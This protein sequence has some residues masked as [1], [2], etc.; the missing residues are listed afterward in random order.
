LEI[1]E[2]TCPEQELMADLQQIVV[3]EVPKP[4][5]KTFV[6]RKRVESALRSLGLSGEDFRIDGPDR[7]VIE[8]PG[9]SVK[10]EQIEQAIHR[11][12]EEQ[13]PF[14]SDAQMQVNLMQSPPDLSFP[15]GDLQI[16]VE[17]FDRPG[18]GIRHYLIGFLLDGEKIEN[19]TFAVQVSQKIPCLVATRDLQPGLLLSEI[20]VEEGWAEMRQDI[21]GEAEPALDPHAVVGT[22]LIHAVAQGSPITLSDIQLT[23]LLTKGKSVMLIQQYG[24]VRVTSPGTLNE[25]VYEIGQQVR[26][27]VTKT[28]ETL[29]G[30][31]QPDGSIRIQ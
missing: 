7:I 11:D 17:D 27:Q 4:G 2:V 1:S 15:P 14:G 20:D 16:Q 23:P 18:S 22:T 30:T 29:V 5:A 21:K 3:G 6:F 8:T 24:S 13:Q 26:V 31:A 19:R 10:A 12:L 28:R 25:D 9:Q